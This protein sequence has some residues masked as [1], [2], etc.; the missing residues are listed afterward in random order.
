MNKF[1]CGIGGIFT[2]RQLGLGLIFSWVQRKS[3]GYPPGVEGVRGGNP[4]NN[5]ETRVFSTPTPLGKLAQ[6]LV[7]LPS[8][9]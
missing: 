9:V 1:G 8:N 6:E 2:D 4:R 7:L 5:S 3:W